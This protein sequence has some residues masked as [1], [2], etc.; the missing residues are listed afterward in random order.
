MKKSVARKRGRDAAQ[1]VVLEATKDNI[2]VNEEHIRDFSYTST[3]T[4][5]CTQP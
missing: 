3:Y 2:Y 5:C 4:Y 1:V